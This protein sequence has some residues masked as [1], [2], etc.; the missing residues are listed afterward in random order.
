MPNP[1][2]LWARNSRLLFGGFFLFLFLVDPLGFNL[3]EGQLE[4]QLIVIYFR[5]D[6][7]D[8]LFF[9]DTA[10]PTIMTNNNR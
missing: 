1:P 4:A 8:F 2:Y 9:S 6:E 3:P 7:H 5:N 10:E